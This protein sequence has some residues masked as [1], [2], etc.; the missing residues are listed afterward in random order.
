[1]QPSIEDLVASEPQDATIVRS[2][3]PADT[4][5]LPE[6]LVPAPSTV[7]APA[8][9]EFPR[10]SPQPEILPLTPSVAGGTEATPAAEASE[11][12]E[13]FAAPLPRQQLTQKPAIDAVPQQIPQPRPEPQPT[14]PRVAQAT[15]EQGKRK[16]EL[17]FGPG[18]DIKRPE[19]RRI[20]EE[21]KILLAESEELRKKKDKRRSGRRVARRVVAGE[22]GSFT[23][24][25]DQQTEY[26][27]N[28]F[29]SGRMR[30]SEGRDD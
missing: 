29:T 12:I 11:E 20:T 17:E 27:K 6:V 8:P 25:E 13:P 14:R 19:D 26:D 18:S 22:I 16:R 10:V 28:Q 30:T 1:V 3:V 7:G 2:L 23:V 21:R 5:L 24:D 4:E 15:E 9:I